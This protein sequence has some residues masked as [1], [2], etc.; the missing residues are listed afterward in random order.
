[1][2]RRVFLSGLV[3]FAFATQAFADTMTDAIVS[4]L[5][6]QGYTEITVRR[7][8]LGRIQ[9]S[10]VSAKQR[11]EI[12]FNPR[13]GEILRDYS[14]TLDG[15]TEVVP[16]IVD[17]GDRPAPEPEP[18]DG[19]EDPED[20]GADD[21]GNDGGAGEDNVDPEKPGEDQSDDGGDDD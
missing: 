6:A 20:D 9:V 21:N 2:R 18:D 16:I 8:F 3:V 17:T 11:R 15:G 13:T 7:T 1:M 10:A 4:Q 12:V 19:G 5:R 14:E